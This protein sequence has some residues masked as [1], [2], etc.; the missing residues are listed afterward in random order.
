M[1]FDLGL[2][3]TTVTPP[4]GYRLASNLSHDF[5]AMRSQMAG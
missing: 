1:I 5:P 4:R 3:Y 2:P